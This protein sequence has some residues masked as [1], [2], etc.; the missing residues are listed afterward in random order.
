MWSVGSGLAGNISMPEGDWVLLAYRVASV[1]MFARCH[2]RVGHA[3]PIRILPLNLAGTT[4]PRYRHHSGY[5]D[6]LN[7]GHSSRMVIVR[8]SGNALKAS[9]SSRRTFRARNFHQTV[10]AGGVGRI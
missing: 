5:I 8:S 10:Q 7:V 4:C 2:Q 3:A 6:P 9:Y 1:E